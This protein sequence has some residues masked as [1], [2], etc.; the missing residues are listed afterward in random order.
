MAVPCTH[1]PGP[2][3]LVGDALGP[4]LAWGAEL[5]C[6]FL[7][8]GTYLDL[9]PRPRPEG[10]GGAIS[11]S[12]DSDQR[13]PRGGNSPRFLIVWL[14]KTPRPYSQYF[15]RGDACKAYSSNLAIR[16]HPHAEL[17]D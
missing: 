5:D 15:R 6:G 8:T 13:N 17:A 3:A 1:S 16:P 14:P 11:L 9:S 2:V 7:L 12:D 4:T 10:G